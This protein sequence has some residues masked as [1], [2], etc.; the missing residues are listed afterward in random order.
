MR[1]SDEAG[2]ARR[3]RPVTEPGHREA[4]RMAELQAELDAMVGDGTLATVRRPDGE[5]GYRLVAGP[6]GLPREE[7]PGVVSAA[8]NRASQ[9]HDRG[10]VGGM[11]GPDRVTIEDAA[12]RRLL[13]AC[14]REDV[15]G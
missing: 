1:D 11:G 14:L 10:C 7:S 8:E 5:V 9:T 15:G 12:G 4:R 13:R 2:T 6:D 3:D